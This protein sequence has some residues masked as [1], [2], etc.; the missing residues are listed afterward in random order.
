VL[1]GVELRS[2]DERSARIAK[3]FEWPML[4]A[5][6]LVIPV[7]VIEA[8]RASDTVKSAA[9]VLNWTIWL[10]FLTELITMLA[11]VPNRGRWLREHPVEV[12]VVVLTPPFMQSIFQSIRALR[13]LRLVRLLRL[14][15]L[16][17]DVFT[18]EGL[19]YAGLVTVL[20]AIGGGYAFA[21][22]EPNRSVGSGV[23]WAITTMTTVGYGDL[24][25]KTDTGKVIAVVVMLVGIGFVA[26]ITGA[27]AHRFLAPQVRDVAEEV[28]DVELAEEDLLNEVRAIAARLSHLEAALAARR[29]GAR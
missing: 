21:A 8:S 11:V 17:R 13:L 16:S 4:A 28:A 20:V 9:E 1:G 27:I 2:V 18:L 5:A 29:T 7:I 19:R 14:A 24:S 25:P 22:T 6:V 10:A 3:R 26:I 23:Y 12:V 15:R